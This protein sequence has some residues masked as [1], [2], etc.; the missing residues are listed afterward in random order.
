MRFKDEN[1]V[2]LIYD[3]TLRL[4]AKEGLGGLT[5]SKIA[6]EAKIATG[7]LYIYFTSKEKLISSLYE[8][9][10][11]KASKRFFDGDAQSHDYQI[12]VKGIWLNYLT[13]RMEFYN[14]SIFMEQFYRSPFITEEQRQLD[15]SMKK[16]VIE[17]IR[18]GQKEGQ[19]SSAYDAEMI[20]HLMLGFIREL[21]NEHFMGYYPIDKKKIDEAFLL[22]WNAIVVNKE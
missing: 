20:L 22:S 21:A 9:L 4:V 13:H 16:P 11:K 8:K 7:T 14:E 5:M 6:K 15:H 18:Y 10:E 2:T 1:K 12:R 3:A 19:I 17:L